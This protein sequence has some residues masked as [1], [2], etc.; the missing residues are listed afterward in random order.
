MKLDIHK[1]YNLIH[2]AEGKEW[3]PAFHTCYKLFELLVI[4][5]GLTN[6]LATFQD[7]T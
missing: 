3:K 4:P 1:A 7:Y 5:F 6:A 2:M